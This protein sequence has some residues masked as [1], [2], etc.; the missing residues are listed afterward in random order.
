M[1]EGLAKDLT[2]AEIARQL[3]VAPNTVRSYLAQDGRPAEVSPRPPRPKL[4]D[5]FVKHLT[6]RWQSGCRNAGALRREI[7]ALGFQEARSRVARWVQGRREHPAT[8]PPRFRAA[9]QTQTIASTSAAVAT[10]FPTAVPDGRTL[11]WLLMRTPEELSPI[12]AR[13]STASGTWNGWASATIWR[14]V[15]WP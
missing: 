3:G 13:S 10:A 8:T 7:K 6:Q 4:I 1:P 2:Q 11:A 15:S 14:S 5:P 9:F 12:K